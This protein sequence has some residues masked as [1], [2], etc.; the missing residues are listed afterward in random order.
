MSVL[1][2]RW[3]SLHARSSGHRRYE[4]RFPQV[5]LVEGF[6]PSNNKTTKLIFPGRASREAGKHHSAARR[7][8]GLVAHLNS[9][10]V[11]AN[12]QRAGVGPTGKFDQLRCI[13][14]PPANMREQRQLGL[15]T[16]EDFSC[17]L[18]RGVVVDDDA[19]FRRGLQRFFIHVVNLVHQEVCAFSEA[20]EVLG[21]PGV[22]GEY[23]RM[24]AV[25][26][27]DSRVRA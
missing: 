23:D 25:N 26:Q 7:N 12:F 14:V 27:C 11:L 17:L 1:R 9:H 13:D 3:R 8:L 18:G 21:R 2:T 16:G 5:D 6:Q 4:H 20:N 24:P 22:A 10:Q 15:H 19:L